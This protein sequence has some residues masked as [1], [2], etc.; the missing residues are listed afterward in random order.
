MLGVSREASWVLGLRPGRQ[1]ILNPGPLGV[2]GRCVEKMFVLDP[3][4]RGRE[5]SSL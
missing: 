4:G 2:P 1:M 5:H 3:G